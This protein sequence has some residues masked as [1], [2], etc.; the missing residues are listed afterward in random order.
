MR[1]ELA[2]PRIDGDTV[3]FSWR[4]SEPDRYLLRQ[5]FSIRYEGLDL[6]AYAETLFVEIWFA[7]LIRVLAAY[8]EPVGVRLPLPLPE[9][10]AAYWLA[11]R[12]AMGQVTVTPTA[13]G[14]A[15][16]WAAGERRIGDRP[17]AISFGG[18]KDSLTTLGMAHELYGP[19]PLLLLH[20]FAPF[21]RRPLAAER[22]AARMERFSLQPVA[23]QTGVTVGRI[24]TDYRQLLIDERR[25]EVKPHLELF[26]I[27]SLPMH[28]AYGV[29]TVTVSEPFYVG[30]SIPMPDGSVWVRKLGLRPQTMDNEWL[31]FRRALGVDLRMIEAGAVFN[32]IGATAMLL[33]RYPHLAG[34]CMTCIRTTRPTQFCYACDP[35]A[36]FG[37]FVLAEGRV[38]PSY[39]ADAMF[40]NDPYWEERF[41]T[42]TQP[43]DVRLPD[44]NAMFASVIGNSGQSQEVGHALSS[45]P[46]DVA[47]TFGLGAAARAR[48]AQMR[49]LWGNAASPQVLEVPRRVIPWVRHPF[50]TDAVELAGTMLPIAD[51]FSGPMLRAEQRIRYDFDA[52]FVPA[53]ADV[54]HLRA[55]LDAVER[56]F[57][58]CG[59]WRWPVVGGVVGMTPVSD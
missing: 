14:G 6:R 15:S 47:A 8:R 57:I 55:P 49:D 39:D 3:E 52:T 17:L 21:P 59:G 22:Y 24:F 23:A 35:C 10:S 30:S 48:L 51:E 11:R 43:L 41:A 40:G 7:M 34:H 42:A 54:P 58:A 25:E 31:H 44:G 9:M 37:L 32:S 38:V 18:G 45:L 33:R 4:Q 19:D 46:D 13:P 36:V 16:P 28:L 50:M 56:A 5:R 53:T 20:L 26:S 27:L 29:E 12:G 2:T 1:V